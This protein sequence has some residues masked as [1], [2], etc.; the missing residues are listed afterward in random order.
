MS[1]CFAAI[2]PHPLLL[3]PNIGKDKI[4]QVEQTKKAMEQL[5]QDIYLAKIELIIIISPHGG[6]FEDTF[7]VNA[8][9]NL[10]SSFDKFGDLVTKKEWKGAPNMAASLSHESHLKN[11]PLRLV[12][13]EQLDHGASVPLYYLTAHMPD[14][15]VLPVGFSHLDANSHIVF[16]ELLKDIILEQ[17]KRV[18]VIASGDLSHRISD[19]SPDGY[20]EYGQQFDNLLLKLLESKDTNG[21]INMDPNLVEEASQCSWRSIL[22]LLGIIQYMDYEFKKYSYEAPHGIGYLVGNFVF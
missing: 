16:G 10:H 9:N 2:T 1:L 14:V 20:S 3:I 22:I 21:I 15:K 8:H 5:E 7:V 17:D 6:L 12:S 19:I 4:G 11:V 13:N 18:A